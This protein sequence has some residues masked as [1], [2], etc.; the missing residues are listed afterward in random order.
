MLT[1]RY[2]DALRLAHQWHRG[3][4]RKGTEV[5]YVA[6]LLA[7]SALVLE[8]GGTED[9]AIAGLLH[10]ALEDAPNQEEADAR[11]GEI[12]H[13]FGEAV[14]AVVEAC[15]DAEPLSKG[16]ERELDG[17]ARREAWRG[18]KARYV[19]HLG[20]VPGAVLLVAAADKVHNAGAIVRDVRTGGPAVFD[21]F[22]GKRDGT[23]WYYRQVL[24]ALEARVGDEPRIAALVL[25]L[26]RWVG[27][28]GE[29]P[30][31]S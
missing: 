14:L 5:P 20:H 31:G 23:L 28:M 13:R 29:G 26:G 24:A 21:R 9:E 18:R 25:E 8:D 7:V 22:V 6:H 30:T 1:Q 27:E 11:R 2:D 19:E 4:K 16:A 3:Q 15:T 17:D 12:R 10:D